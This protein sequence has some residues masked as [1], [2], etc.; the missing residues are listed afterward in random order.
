MVQQGRHHAR[1]EEP[2][3]DG[4][5]VPCSSRDGDIYT[6]TTKSEKER[7]PKTKGRFEKR[8]SGNKSNY[9][10]LPALHFYQ[11]GVFLRLGCILRASTFDI[12]LSGSQPQNLFVALFFKYRNA[13]ING[14][15]NTRACGCGR[16]DEGWA[17]VG[18][19]RDGPW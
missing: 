14:S 6:R 9:E 11:E 3:K 17:V 12:M 10:S 1:R 16:Y 13:K 5:I 19:T 2:A 7:G 8:I 15:A 4:R 18:A